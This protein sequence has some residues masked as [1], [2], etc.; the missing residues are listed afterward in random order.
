MGELGTDAIDR[1]IAP[2]LTPHGDRDRAHVD[3]RRD[4]PRALL[5]VASPAGAA[6]GGLIWAGAI[7]ALL[8]AAGDGAAPT[9]LLAPALIVA[10]GWAIWDRAGRPDPRPPPPRARSAGKSIRATAAFARPYREP[11]RIPRAGSCR[12]PRNPAALPP[13]DERIR[14]TRTA[15]KHVQRGP[16]RRRFARRV[17]VALSARFGSRRV[18]PGSANGLQ[19]ERSTQPRS[20]DR[21]P[22][23]R[24]LQPCLQL[25]GAAGRARPQARQGDGLLQD[26][27]GFAHLCAERVHV[28]CRGRTAA[29]RGLRARAARR[30]LRLP[31]RARAP[32]RTSRC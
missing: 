7:A 26:V 28:S 14:A 27:V 6:V 18:C 5:D 2:L 13:P 10:V 16:P 1:L 4:P 19:H 32:A 21:R 31:A 22:R 30:A 25:R 20:E 29:V 8:G 9:V 3:R 11:R 12:R 23:R 24:R 17:A 15:T